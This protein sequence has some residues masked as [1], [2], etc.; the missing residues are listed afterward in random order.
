MDYQARNPEGAARGGGA[1]LSIMHV[2]TMQHLLY[3]YPTSYT[4][5]I[6]ETGQ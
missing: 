3:I 1:L 4:I 2:P 5:A 6:E